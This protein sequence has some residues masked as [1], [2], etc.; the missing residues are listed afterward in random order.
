MI[1][2]QRVGKVT[3]KHLKIQ[4]DPH[5]PYLFRPAQANRV[6]LESVFASF[7]CMCVRVR[8]G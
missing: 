6:A 2:I 4:P 5:E 7:A 3:E 1:S 8:G